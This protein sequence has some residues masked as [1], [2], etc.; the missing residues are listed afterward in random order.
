MHESRITFGTHYKVL[1]PGCMLCSSPTASGVYVCS[2]CNRDQ[3]NRKNEVSPELREAM[4]QEEQQYLSPSPEKVVW[5]PASGYFNISG[6]IQLTGRSPR[7]IWKMSCL[8]GLTPAHNGHQAVWA[9]EQAQAFLRHSIQ[10]RG[11]VLAL[12]IRD[13]NSI[14]IAKV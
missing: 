3:L 11:A 9:E 6:L 12:A 10:C 4:E 13:D 14:F 2:S 5:H 8:S 7:W 1:Q